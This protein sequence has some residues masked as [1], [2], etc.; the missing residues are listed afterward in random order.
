MP[1]ELKPIKPDAL[2][3]IFIKKNNK[4]LGQKSEGD[5]NT[6]CLQLKA[7]VN[8]EVVPI[9]RVMK[10]TNNGAVQNISKRLVEIYQY[11]S[12]NS[13]V[14]PGYD[15][16]DGSSDS[17][18]MWM[19]WLPYESTYEYGNPKS[20]GCASPGKYSPP[21]YAYGQYQFDVGQGDLFSQDQ[22]SWALIP[23]AYSSYPNE[24]SGFKKYLSYNSKKF[25]DDEEARTSSGLN[26]LFKTYANDDNLRPKFLW[27]Q[28]QT[29]SH[30]YVE[31]TIK[32]LSDKG[33]IDSY[34]YN[35]YILGFLLSLAVRQGSEWATHRHKEALACLKEKINQGK[36]PSNK[37]DLKDIIR[38]VHNVVGASKAGGTGA[39]LDYSD[40]G[41]WADGDWRDEHGVWHSGY[42]GECQRDRA[43][44]DIDNDASVVDFNSTIE[45]SS[46]SETLSFINSPIIANAP[47][48][49]S[50]Y[51][52][53]PDIS[54][55]INVTFR[56]RRTVNTN[57]NS[58]I[59]IVSNL[60]TTERSGY[61]F[62]IDKDNILSFD[63]IS[64][65]GTV[66][67]KTFMKIKED[68]NDSVNPNSG[69]WHSFT[70]SK[71]KNGPIIKYP[72]GTVESG[73]GQSVYNNKEF[74][75]SNEGRQLKLGDIDTN[76]N[77]IVSFKDK[78]VICG[79]DPSGLVED[80]CTIDF[81]NIT[82][83]NGLLNSSTT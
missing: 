25:W 37:D 77:S 71:G 60:S 32:R 58:D 2:A 56:Y 5:N 18:K 55:Y 74:S 45:L 57:S 7:Y 72:N 28:N 14:E 42:E 27:C 1:D 19:G 61:R 51:S 9:K 12:N 8:G 15:P 54:F 34:L 3:N 26:G 24:F 43:L 31:P 29:Y 22:N 47:E 39:T 44:R 73:K 64:K 40:E 30:L 41:R 75:I 69:I 17:I 16:Q 10:I 68:S 80:L 67:K 52:I 76:R 23:F 83:D 46:S 82:S 79:A 6:D 62:Y 81:S 65:N 13:I 4:L 35:P 49:F 36:N 20:V 33:I 63:L 59:N 50:Y 53:D 11:S 70:L 38:S 21:D 66:Y 48:D 78:I